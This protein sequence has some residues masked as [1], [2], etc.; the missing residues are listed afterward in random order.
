MEQIAAQLQGYDPQSLSAD[1]VG[2]FLQRL[3]QPLDQAEEV[4]I[5][6]ALGR[7]LANDLVSPIS[8]PPHDNSA[9]DGYAFDGAQLQGAAGGARNPAATRPAET[10][11]AIAMRHGSPASSAMPTAPSAGSATGRNWPRA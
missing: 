9:M 6:D 10:P 2:Q 8:V 7:V 5:F 3:V 1:H 11:V 4:G